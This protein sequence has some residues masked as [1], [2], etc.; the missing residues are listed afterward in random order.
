MG[1]FLF[2]NYVVCSIFFGEANVVALNKP[3]DSASE[4]QVFTANS[5]TL[6]VVGNA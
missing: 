1:A 2:I 3:F 4:G 5:K 6:I